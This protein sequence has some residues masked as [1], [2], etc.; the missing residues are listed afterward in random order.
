[1]IRRRDRLAAELAEAEK[2][3]RAGINDFSREKGFLVSLRIEQ[4][5]PM[6]GMGN[7]ARRMMH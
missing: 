6:L 2:R 3:V 5:R 7:S 1:M 4:V